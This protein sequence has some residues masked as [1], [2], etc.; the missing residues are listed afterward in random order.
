MTSIFSDG[1]LHPGRDANDAW[2]I[3]VRRR[4]DWGDDRRPDQTAFDPD[5]LTL[6]LAPR[7]LVGTPAIGAT[8]TASDGTRY[9]LD[10]GAGL[11]LVQG[12]CDAAPHPLPGL[13]GAGPATGQ[14]GEPVALAL[15]ERDWLYVV[16]RGNRRVTVIDA[17]DPRRPRVVMTLPV[18]TT[19]PPMSIAIGPSRIYV[20]AADGWI[21]LFDRSFRPGPRFRA[22][23]P[24]ATTTE[25]LGLAAADDGGVLVLARERSLLAHFGCDG[26]FVGTVGLDAAPPALADA[27]GGARFAL[28]GTRIVGPID[29]GRDGLAWHQIAV[30]AELPPGTSIEI[31]TWAADAVIT[32]P[33][34][35][36]TAPPG[37]PPTALAA[38]DP[39]PWA[40][41]A[42]VAMPSVGEARRG[43]LARP[44]LPDVTRWEREQAGPF[45]RAAA[46]PLD[47]AGP[48]ASASFPASYSLARR[49]RAGDGVTLTAAGQPDLTT[50][51]ASIAPRAVRLVASGDRV[52]FGAGATLVLRER[53]GRALDE[54][55]L[56]TLAGA[57]LIDLSVILTD[58][59]GADLAWPHRLAALA[60]DGDL[61]ELR[62][63][64]DVALVAIDVIDSTPAAVTLAA[65][66]AG[67]YRT[68]ALTL[69][70]TADRLVCAHAEAWGD[71]FAPGERIAVT[72]GTG[73]STTVVELTVAWSDPGTATVWPVLPA[74]TWPLPTWQYL[75]AAEPAIATDRGRY[76]WVKLRLRGAR[77][78]PADLD[79][80]ATPRIHAV[81]VVGPRLSYLSY[82]PA[83]YGQ[84]DQDTPTGAV[85]LERFLAMFEGRLTGIEG[86][87]EAVARL[88]NPAGADDDW[89]AFVASWFHLALDPSWPRHRRAALLARI[90]ELYKLRGTRAGIVAFVEAYT[91][92]RPEL[93][94]GFQVR[95]RAGLV[96]GCGG[97]LGCAPL[98]G[99]DADAASGAA[100]LA[101]YAHRLTVVAF[102]DT[103]DCDG[104]DPEAALGALLAAVVPAH[105]DVELRITRGLGRIGV[106]STIGLDFALGVE[107]RRHAPLGTADSRGRPAP[108]LGV[109]SH[110]PSTAPPSGLAGDGAPAPLESFTLR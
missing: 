98:G 88:L 18:A 55:V 49:L 79:A 57:E 32:S 15:D 6:E 10:V 66:A 91:G 38:V 59:G 83:V 20:G 26:G 97:V 54:P 29:G 93:I 71:G 65:V 7:P 14:F 73:A 69:T 76:L 95:P 63:G 109:D 52:S 51:I 17:S 103:D 107:R 42:P 1:A 41:A 68:G 72:T 67:D 11:V 96:L 9:T 85:F 5:R 58:G 106:E 74:P 81:R 86:R 50:T 60:L 2:W 89:L 87:Y 82:L 100:L 61:L 110:L 56:A 47:G 62:A 92:H 84:R 102:V 90:F 105:V 75:T 27:L 39:T 94:E 3:V 64:T 31:Q 77:R 22:L 23:V 35:P 8:V 104:A 53:A 44:V 36:P 30:D 24:G 12:P 108:I 46:W 21:Q 70:A 99:L 48:S 78:H 13:G 101:R 45:P 43:E 25:L 28:E 37:P 80:I 4:E 33:F 16:E 19:A 40:P 34:A